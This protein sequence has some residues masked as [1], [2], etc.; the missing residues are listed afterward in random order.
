[1]TDISIHKSVLECIE[2]QSGKFFIDEKGI[3]LSFEPSKENE[4][5][6]EETTFEDYYVYRTNRSIRTFIVP[7]GVKG[8]VS[9]FLFYTRVIER[10]EL[11]NGLLSIGSY[12]E[13]HHCSVFAGCILPS[14]NIPQSVKELGDF[15]F[16]HSRIETLQLP[17]SIRSPYGRQFKDSY[18]GTLIVPSEWKDFIF[19]GSDYHHLIPNTDNIVADKH[20]Y[21][22]F[23]Y[24]TWYSTYIGKLEFD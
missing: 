8:F 13:P 7:E 1:M 6:I 4:F 22:N 3:A 17:S 11:P 12:T 19:L 16:G 20:Y 14:V 15:A 5:I 18:I 9:N 24:L 10:F 21:M 23:G 2:S